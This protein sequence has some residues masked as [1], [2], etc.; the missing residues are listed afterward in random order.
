MLTFDILLFTYLAYWNSLCLKITR[1]YGDHSP[2]TE[3]EETSNPSSGG[4]ALEVVLF[5]G[6]PSSGLDRSIEVYSSTP[7][8][9]LVLGG[10]WAPTSAHL[11]GGRIAMEESSPL[12]GGR[13]AHGRNPSP[14]LRE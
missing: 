7:P 5:G 9:F 10:K 2:L 13:V 1:Y 11:R 3:T 4:A 12:L 8:L 14:E 6:G